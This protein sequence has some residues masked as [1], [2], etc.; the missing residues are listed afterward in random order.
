MRKGNSIS[1]FL[2]LAR[3]QLSEEINEL[4]TMSFENLMFVKDE[5][6]IPLNYS[7]HELLLLSTQGKSGP[8]FTLQN[9][10]NDANLFHEVDSNVG[11]IMVRHFY[12]LNKHVF[13]YN[14]YEVVF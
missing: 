9:D 10:E 3:K 6:I 5:V 8:L 14:K 11:R 7:F 4:K 13:P 12:D 1:T 2:E